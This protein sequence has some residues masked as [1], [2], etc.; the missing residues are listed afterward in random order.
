MHHPRSLAVKPMDLSPERSEIAVLLAHLAASEAAL[1]A[2]P[3]DSM[4]TA[5]E[6]RGY[7]ALLHIARDA[8]QR[9]EVAS[10]ERAAQL[11][12]V[13]QSS[14][15]TIAYIGC[16]RSLRWISRDYPDA[17]PPVTRETCVGRPWTCLIPH[18]HRDALQ[19]AFD[20]ALETGLTQT[21]EGQEQASTGKTVWYSRRLSR[22][23]RGE[24]VVGVVLTIRDCTEA[25]DAQLQL[26]VSD[27]MASL[28]TLAAGVAHEINNPLAAV[29][30]NLELVC[31]SLRWLGESLPLQRLLFERLEDARSSSYRVRAIVRDLKLFA[32]GDDPRF[33]PVDVEA[34]LESTLRMAT[35]EIRHRAQLVRDYAGV[36]HAWANESRL[37]QVFLNLVMNAAQAIRVGN[38]SDNEIR[39]TTAYDGAGHVVVTIADTGRGID[40]DVAPRL[41]TPFFTTKDVGEGT[42]LGLSIC[43]RILASLG[44]TISF[45]SRVGRGTEFTV[46]LPVARVQPEVKDPSPVLMPAEAPRRGRVLVVD[47]EVSFGKA[48][49]RILQND[50]DTTFIESGRRAL[51]MFRAGERFDVVLCDLMM[52]DMTGMDLHAALERECPEQAA[53]MVFVTGGAFSRRASDFLAATP[54]P[55]VDKPFVPDELRALVGE[56]VSKFPAGNLGNE[57]V[58]GL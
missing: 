34:V 30:T 52:P 14:P 58:D 28:G 19:T 4:C 46:R 17:F 42:G 20:L 3:S 11:D 27:R 45:E 33:E 35:T 21:H 22:V 24:T 15:D 32:R 29:I 41:F 2:D 26:M 16:D 6:K 38:A 57:L 43:R 50:H 39:V 49:Q 54:N 53:A 55:C 10:H 1:L 44:G 5:R 31:N 8:L 9:T 36:P 12:A 23:Q 56:L 40:R 25:K 47:D 18:E 48:T 51:E 13:M 37:G 7:A